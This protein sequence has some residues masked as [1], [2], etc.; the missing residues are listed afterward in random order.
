MSAGAG[1]VL[2]RRASQVLTC[3]GDGPSGLA[4]VDG[5]AAVLVTG[6]RVAWAGPESDIPAGH[7]E[8]A[9]LNAA[10][11]CVV[12]GFVDAHTHLVFG[13]DRAE[14]FEARLAG[15]PYAAGGI[16]TTVAATRAATTGELLARTRRLAIEA[17]S[18]GTTTLEVKSGY[19]LSIDDERRCLE[20]AADL[21]PHV[22]FLGAHVV[23]E[24]RTAGE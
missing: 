16:G 14:E 20:V 9:E 2:V 8:V 13:G 3:T 19:G 10:G 1:S 15:R 6:G 7:G 23:P 18:S 12:P 4:V 22:T 24:D 17:I 11:R 5:P 21:T